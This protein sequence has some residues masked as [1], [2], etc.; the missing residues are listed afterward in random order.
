[1]ALSGEMHQ[2]INRAFVNQPLDEI[3]VADRAMHEDDIR[4]AIK[5]C[6]VAGIGQRIEHRD[7][8]LRMLTP[9]RADEI[10]S[11]ESGAASDKQISHLG[12]F[13]RACRL[14]RTANIDP[15][16]PARPRSWI[17]QAR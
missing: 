15:F 16:R 9:P 7:A 14:A 3:I 8:I 1:M 4:N 10:D 5:A 11:D 13:F 6:S 12:P 2:R 17:Y